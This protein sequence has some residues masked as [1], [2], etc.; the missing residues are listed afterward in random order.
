M[1][2][3]FMIVGIL[4]SVKTVTLLKSF[5]V[6]EGCWLLV[7]A[8]LLPNTVCICRV[9]EVRC[10]GYFRLVG[11]RKSSAVHGKKH[12]ARQPV[13]THPPH[14]SASCFL[15]AQLSLRAFITKRGHPKHL[16]HRIG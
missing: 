4:R 13:Q 16:A 5:A 10:L 8:R 11:V 6:F 14:T 12:E 7:V 2:L 3:L 1:I 15:Y 9:V